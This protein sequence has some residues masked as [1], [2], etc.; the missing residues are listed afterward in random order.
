MINAKKFVSAVLT[1]VL[2]VSACGCS[3]SGSQKKIDAI[4]SV[5]DTFAKSA[6]YLDGKSLLSTVEE[7]DSA[8]ADEFTKKLSM[9][10]LSYDESVVKLAIAETMSYEVKTETTRV[11]KKEGSVDVVFIID[12]YEDAF[13]GLVGYSDVFVNAVKAR[14]SVKRYTV[15]LNLYKGDEGWLIKEESLAGLDELYSFLDYEFTFCADTKDLYDSSKWMFTEGDTY[16]NTDVIELDVWFKA[17]PEEKLYY[18]VGKDGETIYSSTPTTCGTRFNAIFDVDYSGAA[19]TGDFLS[20]GVY[21]IKLFA[22]RKTDALIASAT[23]TVSISDE[24]NPDVPMETSYYTIED[25]SFASIADLGWWDYDSTMIA[26]DTYCADTKTLGFSIKLNGTGPELYYAYYYLGENEGSGSPD[27]ENPLY[28]A[29]IVVQK[30]KDG[31]V[32]YNMDYRPSE[33]KP[34]TYMI[35]VAADED[36]LETPYITATCTVITQ[37]RAEF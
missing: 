9:A 15:T 17:D 14:K 26:D 36:S 25:S 11:E 7:I 1:G 32:Y 13:D 29:R 10:D 18:T 27:L 28:D 24:L 5:A 3:F 22:V 30:Y 34:G 4:N 21:T 8:K 6:C 31:T 35:R 12:D 2:L 33:L 23:A 19:R 37:T 20:E 16:I